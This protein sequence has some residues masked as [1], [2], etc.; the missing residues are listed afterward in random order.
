MPTAEM[1][2]ASRV[3]SQSERNLWSEHFAEV[4]LLYSLGLVEG[5]VR[6]RGRS[7]R[8]RSVHGGG[9]PAID[10]PERGDSNGPTVYCPT[11]AG[12]QKLHR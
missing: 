6:S 5:E 4:H 1:A 3:P 2:R 7:H 10:A 9:R 12:C 11:V 8:A